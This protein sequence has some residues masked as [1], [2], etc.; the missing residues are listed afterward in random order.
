MAARRPR[1][2][3]VD[4]EFLYVRVAPNVKAAAA[5][6]AADDRR[7]VA[8][9]VEGIITEKLVDGGYLKPTKKGK[10]Q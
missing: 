7:S 1:G 10:G 4:F 2:S 3:A 9:W 6:A 8:S 5:E